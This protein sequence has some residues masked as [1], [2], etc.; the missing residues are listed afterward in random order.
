MI[1]DHPVLGVG[2]DNFVYLYQQF[3]LRDGAVAEPSLSHPHNWILNF[4]LSLG[5]LGLAAFVWLLVCF[6][7]QARGRL[8]SWV[9][10]GALGA[11]ADMLVHGFID[12]SYFL[13]DL[14][15]VFWLCLALVELD[16]KEAG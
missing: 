1:R 7:R 10:A 5:V 16:P 8:R 9:V 6:W 13:V 12:N 15:F 11:M 4:W 14:A 2:L 3:Y